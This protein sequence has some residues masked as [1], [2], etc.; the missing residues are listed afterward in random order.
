MTPSRGGNRLSKTVEIV[1][2]ASVHVGT[3]GL[4]R[5]CRGVRA[6][7]TDDLVTGTDQFGDDGGTEMTGCTGDEL[8]W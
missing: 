4:D 5:G 3:Q 6:D 2:G 1:E 7:Q 8:S